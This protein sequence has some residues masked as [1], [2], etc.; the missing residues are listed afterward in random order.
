MTRQVAMSTLT[1]TTSGTD[2][3]SCA[4]LADVGRARIPRWMCRAT[5]LLLPGRQ[6]LGFDRPD[7]GALFAGY[8]LEPFSLQIAD[9]LHANSIGEGPRDYH[10]DAAFRTALDEPEIRNLFNEDWMRSR[11]FRNLTNFLAVARVLI[12]QNHTTSAWVRAV[13]PANTSR[14][15]I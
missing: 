5:A 4:Q 11:A 3:A 9:G 12:P 14:F 15:W 6:A 8:D 2:S 10:R 13:R 1:S 7:S